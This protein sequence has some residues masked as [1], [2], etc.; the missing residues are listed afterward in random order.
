LN[1]VDI[2]AGFGVPASR[3]H[4]A[5]ELVDALIAAYADPGPHLIEAIVPPIA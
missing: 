2:A 1:F 5:E 3:V 4:T